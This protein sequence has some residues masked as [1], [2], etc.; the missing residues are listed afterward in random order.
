MKKSIF[1]VILGI[2]FFPCFADESKTLDGFWGIPWETSFNE[3]VRILREKPGKI[4]SINEQRYIGFQGFFAGEDA[5]ISFYFEKNKFINVFVQYRCE[6]NT[7]EETYQK[8]KQMLIEKYGPAIVYPEKP[9]TGEAKSRLCAWNFSN[10]RISI[11]L[12]YEDVPAVL[13]SYRYSSNKTEEQLRQSASND[14]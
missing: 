5:H 13:I 6:E 14:L 3:T 8:Y 4:T 11:G 7:A 2:I 10:A 1:I 12:M 9:G